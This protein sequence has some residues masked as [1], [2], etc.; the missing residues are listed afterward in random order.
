M[1]KKR[2]FLFSIFNCLLFMCLSTATVFAQ[3]AEYNA[4]DIDSLELLLQKRSLPDDD[5]IDTYLMLGYAY[6]GVDYDKSVEYMQKGIHLSE[7]NKNYYYAA[8]S[9][10]C[11]GFV[12][13]ALSQLDSALYYFDRS[14]AM[15]DLAVE[16]KIGDKED[17]DFLSVRIYIA[18]AGIH[19]YRGQYD[20]SLNDYLT[21]LTLLKKMDKP[22]VE[23][24]VYINIGEV[25]GAMFNYQ[26]SENYFLKSEQVYRTM[27]DS[28]G[29][30]NMYM[31]L[32]L[33]RIHK[34]DYPKALE[35]AEEGHRI[36]LSMP[37]APLDMLQTSYRRLSEAWTFIPDY[38]KALTYSK[39]SVELAKQTGEPRFLAK[40]LF[41]LSQCYQKTKRYKESEET[42]FQ[43]LAIDS[44]D[45]SLNSRLYQL[46]AENNVWLNNGE[47]AIEYYNKVI[48]FTRDFANENFQNSLSEMEV[49][50]ET[51]KKELEIERQQGDIKNKT[52]QRNLFA[53][54]V[55]LSAIILALLWYLLRLRNRNNRTL[56]EMN[57]TKDKFFS[58]ISH[59]LKNPAVAQRDAIRQLVMNAHLWDKD[60]LAAYCHDLL[61]SADAELELLYSLLG[62]AQIQTERIAFTPV[63]FDLPAEL[64]SDI[65]LICKMA[66]AKNITFTEQTPKHLS[67]TGDINMLLTVVRNLLTN[68]VKFTHAG[69]E[70]TL[71]IEP[72][73]NGKHSVVVSDT[74]IG[75]TPEE[76]NNLFSMENLTSNKGTMGEEGTRLGLIVCKELLKKHESTLFVESEAGKGSK[77][78]FEI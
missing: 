46:I 76:V 38:D 59:D 77:F 17:L 10:Y 62:W 69:G 65:S 71:T 64:R 74:G 54:G 56:A 19:Y 58:I 34:K 30:S 26:Q 11:A 2:N 44:T 57:A 15:H 51:T 33:V 37:N 78:W 68:A 47:K 3:Y 42:A 25:F 23:A 39:K 48:A 75:M 61:K 18:F 20:L 53:G 31:R 6:M 73:S 35:Y 45:M 50:Y 49:K 63:T 8:E 13:D 52:L 41:Q 43:V 22:D 4:N 16:K 55:A 40:A 66:E 60:E 29:I 1:T 36:L 67:V 9:Y 21:A 7:K 5:R 24:V 72:A 14:L 12:Q 28:I 70:I 27:G 32:S